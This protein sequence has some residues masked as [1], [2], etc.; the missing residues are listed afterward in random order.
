MKFSYGTLSA[1]SPLNRA[2]NNTL[3]YYR[4]DDYFPSVRSLFY[5]MSIA[6]SSMHP[7]CRAVC[8]VAAVYFCRIS[9]LLRLC[10]SDVLEPDRAICTGS[11]RG[12][13]YVIFLPGLSKQILLSEVSDPTLPLFP[14]SYSQ[15]YRSY[16]RAGISLFRDGFKNAARCHASR[17]QV[18]K[19][20]SEGKEL[21]TLSDL[22]HHK[23]KSS[24]LYYLNR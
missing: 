24:I 15:C 17:Y 13:D 9:E 4:P 5:D 18:S 11:K 23:S 22:L 1:P 19:L 20:H 2:R 7:V 6:E 16:V 21:N 14:V 3:F 8:R 10:I 12:S